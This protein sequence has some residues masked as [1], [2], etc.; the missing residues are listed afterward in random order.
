MNLKN[1]DKTAY[2]HELTERVCNLTCCEA[3]VTKDSSSLKYDTYHPFRKYYSLSA[4]NGALNKFLIGEWDDLMLS[5]W[6]YTYLWILLGGCDCKNI[7]ESLNSFEKFCRDFITW[8]LDGLSFFDQKY[9]DDPEEDI[10][11]SIRLFETYDHVW[12][13]RSK[14]IAHYAVIGENA[15]HN[16]EQFVL[17]INH[18]EKE[19]MIMYSDHIENGFRDKYFKFIPDRKFIDLVRRTEMKEYKLLPCDEEFYFEDIAESGY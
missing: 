14:W 16:G 12:Q 2:D 5:H 8:A 10:R 15:K 7:T 13:T 17:L 11:M 19:Y 6:A 3:D 9:S 18:E 4:I 1:Q